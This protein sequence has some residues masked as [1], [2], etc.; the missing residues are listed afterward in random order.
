MKKV[1]ELKQ[2]GTLQLETRPLFAPGSRPESRFSKLITASYWHTSD[3]RAPI[4]DKSG[5]ISDW[6]TDETPDLTQHADESMPVGERRTT[7]ENFKQD[8]SSRD[9]QP[10]NGEKSINLYAN[11]FPATIKKIL[12]V[13]QSASANDAALRQC[14]QLELSVN[15]PGLPRIFLL[16]STS[17]SHLSLRIGVPDEPTRQLISMHQAL[18][19]QSLMEKTGTLTSI[20]MTVDLMDQ[21]GRLSDGIGVSVKCAGVRIGAEL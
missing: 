12:Q 10:A 13:V 5:H 16:L 18:L 11:K 6:L 4:M 7:P 9:I 3:L 15:Q 2:L 1:G 14:R 17:H 19:E 8:T 21:E 20:S